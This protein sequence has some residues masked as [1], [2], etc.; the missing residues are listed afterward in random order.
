MYYFFST[1]AHLHKILERMM[2][3]LQRERERERGAGE[4]GKGEG[5]DG[6][7]YS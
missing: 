5:S 3:Y 6:Y 7:G 1:D 4:E 2:Q